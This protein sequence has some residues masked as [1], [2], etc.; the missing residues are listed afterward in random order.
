MKGSYMERDYPICPL[1]L[2]REYDPDHY[3]DDITEAE[4]EEE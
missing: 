1:E 4:K 2:Q 3:H